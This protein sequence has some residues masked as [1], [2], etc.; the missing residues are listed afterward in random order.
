MSL[1]KKMISPDLP[2]CGKYQKQKSENEAT[3]FTGR[4]A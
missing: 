2:Y 1:E 3:I 4:I